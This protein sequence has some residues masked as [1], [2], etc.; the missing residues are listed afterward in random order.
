[1]FKTEHEKKAWV[2][3]LIVMAIIIALMFITGLKYM[4]PP[5]PGNIAVN[6]GFDEQGSGTVQPE[7]PRPKPVPKTPPPPQEEPQVT[8]QEKILTSDEPEAPVVKTTKKKTEK[9][10][11]KKKT[12]PPEK[13]KPSKETSEVLNNILNAPEGDANSR[14]EGD[15]PGKQGDKGNPAGDKNA[16]N[17]YGAGGS[18]GNDP[19]YQLGNRR[20]ITKP[21][22]KYN[23]NEEGKVVVRITVNR[24]GKVIHAERE[25]GTTASS[26]L[27]E[28]AIQAAYNTVWEKDPNAEA[29]QIGT[30]TY[31]FKLKE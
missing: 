4:D 24:D 9:K 29:K 15:D 8:K 19:N 7:T 14:S 17:Y 27:T 30:I 20:A 18:G 2:E 5:P 31:Y 6:F 21:A 10:K 11:K 26:C 22:P 1:M 25:K 13:P 16:N 3:T 12:P 23:C 28:A